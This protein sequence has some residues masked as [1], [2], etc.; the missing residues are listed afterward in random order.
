MARKTKIVNLSLPQETY[1]QVEELADQMEVS[2]SEL[3]REALKNYVAS[4]RRWQQIRQKGQETA[5]KFSIK[6]ED[7]VDRIIHEYRQERS[8]C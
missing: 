7:D 1:R 2:K 8:R 5:K 6:D 4:E 3:L